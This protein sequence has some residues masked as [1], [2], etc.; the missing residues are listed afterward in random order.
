M[1]SLILLVVLWVVVVPLG[2]LIAVTRLSRK[3]EDL[4]AEQSGLRAL[5]ERLRRELAEALER[6]E[7]V[8]ARGVVPPP[9]EEPAAMWVAAV[10]PAPLTPVSSVPPVAVASVESGPAASS[11]EAAPVPAA[12]PILPLPTP[13]LPPPIPVPVMKA[14]PAPARPVLPVLPAIDWE[15]FMGVKLFA[16]LGGLALFLAVAFFVKYS[17]ENNLVP[18]ELRVALGFLTGLGLLMGGVVLKR[19]AYEATSQTLCGTGTVILY[20]VSFAC[21]AYYHFTGP[22][23]TF[24][25]MA[26]VT[27]TAFLLAVRMNALVVAILGIVGGFLT[28]PLLSTG[29]DNPAGLFGYVAILD[30][31]LVAVALKRRWPFLTAFGVVGTLLMV[32][33]WTHE[34]YAVDKVWIAWTVLA[35]FNGLF[36]AAFVTGQRLGQVDRWL[37]GSALA[38]PFATFAYALWLTGSREIGARPGVLFCFL[39]AADL[40]VLALAMRHQR[41]ALSQLVA[42]AAAF[43]VLMSWTGQHLSGGLLNWALAG[44]LGFAVLHTAFPVVLQRMRPGSAPVWWGHLFPPL[45]L[46]LVLGPLFREL[47]LTWLVWPVVML[48]DAAA[49]LLALLTGAVLGVVAVLVLTLG[50]AAVWILQTPA[51]LTGLPPMLFVVGGFAVFFFVV[52]LFGAEKMMARLE[53]AAG[54][55]AA[56]SGADELPAFLRPLGGGVE[57]RAQIPA[58]SAI[59][60]FLLLIM[61]VTRLPLTNPSPVYGLALL[62]VGLVLGLARLTRV[63]VLPLVG[64]ICVLALE[65]VW[66]ESRFEPAQAGVALLWNVGFAA[67]F[68]VYPFLFRATFQGAVAPWAAA[69]LSGPLHFYLVHHAMKLGYP[70]GAMGLLPAAFAVPMILALAAVARTWAREA[71]DRM[72]L[73]A[74]FG[75]SALFFITL[76]FPVQFEKQWITLGWGLEGVAVLWL[77]RRIPHPGLRGLG[78][79]LLVIAFIRLAVNPAV[80]DYH[81]RSA[82]RIWNWYLYSY[83]IITL[84]LLGGARLLVPPRDRLGAVSLPALFNTLGTVLAFLLLNVEIADYFSEGSSL[85]FQFSGSFARD[86]TYSIGWALFALALLSAGVL[87]RLRAA[88][89]AALGLLGV[90]L[91]KLFLHDLTALSALYRIGAFLGVA[92]ISILASVLYQR[93]FAQ[94]AAPG[95][96]THPV[97]S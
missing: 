27:V 58:M 86:M 89:Y 80:F 50:V 55:G 17:F 11:P 63:T 46:L 48:I 13:S 79:A 28:P 20:A 70:N 34:F 45:A 7:R 65:Y 49:V 40:P 56:G 60:P 39:L 12:E 87:R 52:G 38:L 3:T 66:H 90:T 71:K 31:G 21:H 73:L 59:L 94:P 30:A 81:P 64:L 78:A 10:E 18:P 25:L 85:T 83:G 9:A 61:M 43:V 19:K 77:Y 4:A 14:S 93:F 91:L 51:E 42:G 8:E 22:T 41:A 5:V 26:L 95:A 29:V 68:M 69:A 75:G 44:Y 82:V 1:E 67:I 84:C 33:G 32:V 54:G 37:T 16:W 74:W 36:L 97:A 15:Q 76:I 24:G 23:L 92:V 57:V 35:G 62:L 6:V 53:A 47:Q 88:R 72:A 2:C 96:E